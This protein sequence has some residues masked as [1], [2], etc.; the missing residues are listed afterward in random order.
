MKKTL[1][2]GFTDTHDH[3]A[4]FFY[5][6]LR[7]RYNIEIDNENPECL[8]FGDD[9]FGHNNKR[10]MRDN[11]L[12][13]FYT[14]ENRRPE[15]FDCDYAISFDHN[16]NSWHYRLP[17]FVIC[18]WT[19]EHIHKAGYRYDHILNLP[20][21]EKKTDFC[22]FVVSNPHCE[23][24]NIFFDKLNSV[25]KVDSAGKFKNN[26]NVDLKTLNDK[27]NFISKRKFN[28][29]FENSSYPGYVTEKILDSFYARSIPI[30]WGSQTVDV[31]FNPN[32]FINVNNYSNVEDVINDIMQIDSN[33]D[34][35]NHIVN[36]PK[37]KYNIPPNYF[38]IENLLNWF[39]A[40]ISRKLEAKP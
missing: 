25:K 7:T 2:L 18:M 37:F 14:G 30:Y 32:S 13:I 12:K 9:N 6:I 22:S 28:I 16:F 23:Q 5:N 33:D 15:N 34:L 20:E 1:K 10:F 24:R 3:I 19:M 38:F 29:C 39:D 26:I 11:V 4:T 21:P 31:D 17:L 40:A 27:I 8:I 36:Q 35:Y